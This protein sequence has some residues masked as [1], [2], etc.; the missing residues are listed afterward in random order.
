MIVHTLLLSPTFDTQLT[1]VS[2]G[3]I[4]SYATYDNKSNKANIVAIW[5]RANRFNL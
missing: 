3:T 5:T 1:F 4:R 2:S